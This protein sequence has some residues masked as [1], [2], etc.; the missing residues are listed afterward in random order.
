MLDVIKFVVNFIL[1]DLLL[2]DNCKIYIYI[3][4]TV[5][6]FIEKKDEK[7]RS[8]RIIHT[9]VTH[10]AASQFLLDLMLTSSVEF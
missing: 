6:C 5:I 10:R 4:E 2:I 7:E 8:I 9:S 3:I 1:A